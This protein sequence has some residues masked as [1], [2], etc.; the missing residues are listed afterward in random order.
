MGED[1][2]K[3]RARSPLEKGIGMIAT[4]RKRMPPER[5]KSEWVAR[6]ERAKKG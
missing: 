2:P 5:E 4:R 3:V 1:F 6:R